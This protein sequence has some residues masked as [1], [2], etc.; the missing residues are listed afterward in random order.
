MERYCILPPIDVAIFV[1][2]FKFRDLVGQ[3]C[4]IFAHAV[5]EY[6]LL[7]LFISL[8]PGLHEARKILD[9]KRFFF[10]FYIK[11]L[12]AESFQR[13]VRCLTCFKHQK[14]AVKQQNV[15]LCV[16]T[17][18]ASCKHG[19]NKSKSSEYKIIGFALLYALTNAL[20][21]ASF[22]TR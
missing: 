11:R 14:R 12:S 10:L 4:S 9:V 7:M 5:V 19:F 20:S 22:K 16:K 3:R 2:T 8:K 15:K 13:T 17:F 21:K 1:T 6:L 18:L